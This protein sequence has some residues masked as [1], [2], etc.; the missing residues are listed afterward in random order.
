MKHATRMF[1]WEEQ[2]AFDPEGSRQA[3]AQRVVRL[4]RKL[5]DEKTGRASG[6][7]AEQKR[8][9]AELR[10]ARSTLQASLYWLRD[11]NHLRIH[12]HKGRYAS[13]EYEPIVWSDDA[14]GLMPGAPGINTDAKGPS[15]RASEARPAGHLMPG[16]PGT[17]NHLSSSNFSSGGY[18]PRA[19]ARQPSDG[20]VKAVD[21]IA[22]KAPQLDLR[23]D[24]LLRAYGVAQGWADEGMPPSLFVDLVVVTAKTAKGP[25]REFSYFT[26][27]VRRMWDA[28]SRPL[29]TAA[30]G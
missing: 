25:I 10:V 21:E 14:V 12:S 7:R 30:A 26:P 15:R 27:V 19:R 9:A 16:A 6:K 5:V 1:A 24:R 22:A 28:A 29:P 3:T 18:H 4:I 11:R 8:M 2:V 20:A 17:L 23:G 13:D